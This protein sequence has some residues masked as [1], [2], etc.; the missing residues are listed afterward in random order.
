MAYTVVQTGALCGTEVVPV[1]IE[2]DRQPGLPQLNIIG[3]PD[4]RIDE[5]K[6]RVR[7]AIKNSGFSFPL[8][9]ITVNLSPSDLPK[10]G[11]G[12]DVGIALGVLGAA[13]LVPTWPEN[14]W[15]F[16]EL[17]LNG[18]V[19]PVKEAAALLVAARRLGCGGCVVPVGNQAEAALVY[20][21]PQVCIQSLREIVNQLSGSLALRVLSPP[22]LPVSSPVEYLIDEVVGQWEAKRAV[23]I[24]VAGSHHLLLSG[25]PGVGKSMLTQG[26]GQLLPPLE[27]DAA[28]SVACVYAASKE[29]YD[30]TTD[31][32]PV[33]FPHHTISLVGMGGGGEG[34]PGEVSL[35][36]RGV[37]VLD[38]LP[39]YRRCVLDAL[40]LALEERQV[41]FRRHGI[42]YT[43]PADCTVIATQN[44]CP[45]GK[46]GLVKERCRCLPSDI[47]RYH[48]LLT[49]PLL[50]RFDL[51]VLVPLV[52][53]EQWAKKPGNEAPSGAELA[54][55]VVDC[56][57]RQVS[58]NPDGC[59]NGRLTYASLVNMGASSP[60]IDA[61]LQKAARRYAL[62]VRAIASVLRV[63]RTIADWEQ[64]DAIEITHIHEALQYRYRPW[65]AT[66]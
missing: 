49:P 55:Q 57:R 35:T 38:E 32:A 59:L 9:R 7:S 65:D 12:Y 33:R 6:E 45:C 60:E 47:R 51:S 21:C 37:L 24:A 52:P 11:T 17:S 19:R 25:P 36:H 34:R 39:L 8:G 61:L 20:D 62:S 53:G 66:G 23:C 42:T 27:R 26:A 14:V 43:F 3:L 58:R 28:L 40:R 64:R 50:E 10:H 13:G 48:S 44:P 29:S 63:A 46:A 22:P 4:K 16:G 41:S 5:A 31:R 15:V 1:R 56:R 54:G 2:V 30:F 18:E